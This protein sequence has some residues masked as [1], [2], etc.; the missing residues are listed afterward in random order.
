MSSK[1]K[2]VIAF[3]VFFAIAAI[4]G[5]ALGLYFHFKPTA[6]HIQTV[7]STANDGTIHSSTKFQYTTKNMIDDN[8]N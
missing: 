7:I 6:T 8:M 2:A 5:V 3:A 4:I 1:T